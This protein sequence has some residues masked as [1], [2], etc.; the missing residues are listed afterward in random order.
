M[1][2]QWQLDFYMYATTADY[3]P[4]LQAMEAQRS[5]TYSRCGVFDT[6]T[7]PLFSSG[8]ELPDFGIAT[9]GDSAG[10]SAY[11]VMDT[12]AGLQTDR[13]EL[14]SGGTRYE[15]S[16]LTN[17]CSIVFRP[18]GVFEERCLIQGELST[19]SRDP[20]SVALYRAFVREFKK[21]FTP[22][23][24]H[25]WLGPEALQR[26]REGMRLTPYA[27]VRMYDLKPEPL[28]LPPGTPP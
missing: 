3:E 11:L 15:V 7:P 28:A 21:R 12:S 24:N 27:D 10:E 5:L 18:G 26:F 19:V 22:M 23:H 4:V 25:W 20:A 13:F 2:R 16:Q 17:P 6:P 9:R 14:Y 1:P 8:L